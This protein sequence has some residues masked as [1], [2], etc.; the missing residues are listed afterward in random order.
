LDEILDLC[1]RVTVFKDGALVASL[2]RADLNKAAL[3]RSIV[4]SDLGEANTVSNAP[5]DRPVLL[6][7]RG[8]SRR[9]LVRSASF[10]VHDREVVGLAGL[11]GAGRSELVRMIYGADRPEAG[12]ILMAGK[13]I[14]IRSPYDAVRQGIVLVPEERRSQGLLLDKTVAFNVNIPR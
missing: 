6:E 5:P 10:P 13:A 8:L 7:V 12:Q 3:V 9:H 1:Q 14:R 2:P 11:V 4:G